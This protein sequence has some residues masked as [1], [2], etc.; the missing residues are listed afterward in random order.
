MAFAGRPLP[1]YGSRHTTAQN[2]APQNTAHDVV[3]PVFPY[4]ER[5]ATGSQRI[6][7]LF[8]LLGAIAVVLT[9]LS[10]APRASASGGQYV[11]DGGTAAE[12]STVRSALNASSFNWG[13]VPG[14]ITI[15]ITRSVTTEATAGEIW[16]D[17]SLLDSGQFAWGIVQHEFAHQVDFLLLNDDERSQLQTALG[18]KDWCY[19]DTTLQHAQHGCERFASTLA[20]AYW[21]SSANVLKPTAATDESAAMTPA[22]FRSLLTSILGAG[23]AP[24]PVVSVVGHAPVVKTTKH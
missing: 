12:Q 20:W 8:G 21:Q 14:T 15:H 2:T 19:S 23:A 9:L 5:R 6:P 13:I 17:A 1:V 4:D 3:A 22:A 7:A 11:F 18:A 10:T 24:T 16:L